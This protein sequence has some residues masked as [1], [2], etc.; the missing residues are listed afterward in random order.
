MFLQTSG[1][2]ILTY[3]LAFSFNFV[4]IKLAQAKIGRQEKMC[5][6]FCPLSKEVTT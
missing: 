4:Q 1:Q 2:N 5:L 3:F 6:S